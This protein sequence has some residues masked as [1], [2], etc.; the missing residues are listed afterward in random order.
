MTTR[1]A[2]PPLPEIPG[3]ALA[4]SS[5]LPG[6]IGRGPHRPPP[7]Q[8]FIGDLVLAPARVHEICG[9]ARR[10]A[11][12]MLAARMRGPVLWIAPRWLPE[13][14]HMDGV[15][16]LIDPARLLFV[17][18]KR[19][20]D[21]LWSL[22]EAL[23]AGCVPLCVAEVPG[24]PRLTPVR[25]LHLAAETGAAEGAGPPLGLL[26]TPG[27]GGAEGVETR[28]EMLPEHA[29]GGEGWI[30]HRRRARTAPQKSWRIDIPAQA[31]GVPRALQRP[32][33]G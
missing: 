33:A 12:L 27:A 30:L 5:A 4:G 15:R 22:E 31:G 29:P 19:P 14:L 20:E 6:R 24:Y 1:A 28:W 16:R 7:G 13:R 25:R 17:H 8:P 3:L 2:T 9:A 10:T 21:L 23:R 32:A 11:A 18:P 26:L